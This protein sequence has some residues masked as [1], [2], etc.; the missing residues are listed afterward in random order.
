[1]KILFCTDGSEA[2]YFAIK[3]IF[4]F[5]QSDYRIDVLN[6]IDWGIIP[7]Y[8]TFPTEEEVGFPSQKNTSEALLEKTKEFIES[9][10]FN[11]TETLNI[12][13]HPDTVIID[14]IKDDNYDLA[15]LGSHGKKGIR[16]W[17]GSVSRKVITKSPAPIFV[18][19]PT[20]NET[21]NKNILI[22]CD[23]S[24]NSYNAIAKFINMFNLESSSIEI[25]TIIPGIESFPIE[26]TMDNEWLE[27][28]LSKQKDIA[29]E[30]LESASQI[31]TEK[32]IPIKNTLFL[33]GDAAEE[34]LKY[35]DKNPKDMIVMGTHGREGISDFLL[36]SV[37]KRIL[38]LSNSPILIIPNKK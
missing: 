13:G 25:I 32:N 7:T 36:G 1:M 38:D 24:D 3:T 5:L 11:I 31:F 17:L 23:G 16:K 33:Q 14:T 21:H 34:I 12:S 22:T 30:V 26:I 28:C 18:A 29:N 35:T 8:V 10:G 27:S 2:S 15:I 19:K 37:S 20:K 6:V 4:P 9:Y